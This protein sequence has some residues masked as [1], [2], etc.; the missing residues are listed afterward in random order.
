MIRP[1]SRGCAVLLLG[2]YLQYLCFQL[3]THPHLFRESRTFSGSLRSLSGSVAPQDR[4]EGGKTKG[5]QA[6]EPEESDGDQSAVSIGWDTAVWILCAS[7]LLTS[8]CTTF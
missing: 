1:V 7:I 6:R 2:T 3:Y 4:G 8:F 5:E